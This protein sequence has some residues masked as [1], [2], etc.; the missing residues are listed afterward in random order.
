M[1]LFKQSLTA[2]CTALFYITFGAL[3]VIWTCI[4]YVYLFNNHPDSNTVYYWC[5]G[6]FVTGVI[7]IFIGVGLDR[8]DRLSRRAGVGSEGVSFAVVDAPLGVP[9]L[10]PPAAAVHVPVPAVAPDGEVLIVKPR[11][12][13][14]IPEAG[15]ASSG[16]PR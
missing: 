2:A 6:F 13:T 9:A 16:S 10:A 15:A 12:A 8:I 7:L 5:T 14:G 4:W 11:E 3:T 1:W